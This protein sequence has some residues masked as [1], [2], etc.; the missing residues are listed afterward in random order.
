VLSLARIA[1]HLVKEGTVVKEDTYL[2]TVLTI[3]ALCLLK[4]AFFSSPPDS[5]AQ[6]P[7]MSSSES[8]IDVNLKSIDGNELVLSKEGDLSIGEKKGVKL[9]ERGALVVTIKNSPR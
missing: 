9:M 5:Y 1:H 4:L 6:F 7:F 3:I 8:L 2:K